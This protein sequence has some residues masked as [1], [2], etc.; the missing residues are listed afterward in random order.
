M[1]ITNRAPPPT[2]MQTRFGFIPRPTAPGSQQVG[3]SKL[4]SRSRSISPTS[5]VSANS[6][7]SSHASQRLAKAHAASKQTPA[8]SVP[9]SATTNSASKS[10][11]QASPRQRDSS[12]SKL[13]VKSNLQAPT[14]ASLMRSRTPSRTSTASPSSLSVTS[15]P[16]SAPSSSSSSTYAA[17]T[18]K[19]DVNA[20]RD[21]Y[22]TQKR[23]NFFTRHTPISTANGSPAA[24]SV[25]SPEPSIT[26][27]EKKP[28]SPK[29]LSTNTSVKIKIKP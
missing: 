4:A 14:T 26:D 6:S 12:V 28:S 22:K 18:I 11:P 25:K 7:S 8:R 20:I 1:S 19:T 17:A 27:K 13:N 3:T 24:C 23:M 29:S 16:P 9:S 5:T 2:A 15:P 10:K 21:R